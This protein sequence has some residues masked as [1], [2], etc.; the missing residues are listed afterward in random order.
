MTNSEAMRTDADWEHFARTDAYWAV[1]TDERFRRENFTEQS[2][3]SFFVSGEANIRDVF[4]TIRSHLDPVFAPRRALD[5][6]CGVG[7]VLLP[8]AY[9]CAEVVGVDVSE[10]ML[11]EATANCQARGV[12]N[13]TLVK[14]DD[15][16]SGVCGLFDL[17]HTFIVLQHV[18]VE[19]GERIFRRL[20][21]LVRPGGCGAIHVT[22]AAPVVPRPDPPQPPRK[23]RGLLARAIW[24]P[25]R[26]RLFGPRILPPIPTPKA[27]EMQ[28]NV[29]SLNSLLCVLQEAGVER[30]YIEFT[31]HVW[32]GVQLFFRKNEHR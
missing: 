30:L 3:E 31:N 1:L 21:E 20:V 16:L 28:M 13:V 9:R 12:E 10:T 24:R 18:P 14:G 2:R 6:G 17:V 19:R 29:Y 4:D 26:R 32:Y 8:L 11:R 5:F 7:R 15:E 27:P 25:L 23:Q 22:Y